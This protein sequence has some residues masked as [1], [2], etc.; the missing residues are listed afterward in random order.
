MEPLLK[1]FHDWLFRV[2][3]GPKSL[4]GK[5]AHYNR[6]QWQWLTTYLENAGWRYPTT[7]LSEA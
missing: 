3:D 5:A 1:E 7:V 4:L 2:N 6:E